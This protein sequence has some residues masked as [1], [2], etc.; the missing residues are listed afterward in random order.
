MNDENLK[1]QLLTSEA[2]HKRVIELGEQISKDYEGLH[3]ILVSVLKGGIYFMTDLTR[4]ITIPINI[5]FMAIGVYSGASKSSGIVRITKEMDISITDRH[6]LL[7][8]DIVGTG[9]TLSYIYQH[10][11]NMK[12][13]SLKICTFFDTPERRLVN[14][15]IAYCGFTAPEGF[16][17][18]YG[19]DYKEDYRHL[20]Y[21]T[22]YVEKAG[23]A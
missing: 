13:A 4:A 11:E 20:P 9:L 17:V 12:P 21:I 10:L 15:P 7:V 3:P 22:R 2:I 8:E 14:I 6:V 23:D 19:L 5:D 16:L 1:K 18:G